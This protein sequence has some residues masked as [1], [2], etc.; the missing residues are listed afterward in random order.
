MRLQNKNAIFNLLGPILLNGIS[1]F[2]MPIF[3]RLLGPA[4]YGIVAVFTTWVGILSLI[5][6]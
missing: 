4:Q 1:F 3:T 2:T 5:H 6:I